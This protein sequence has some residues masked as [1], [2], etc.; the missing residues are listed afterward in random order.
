VRI[1]SDGNVLI[2][3]RDPDTGTGVATSLPRIIADEL[4][5]DWKSVSVVPL[6]LGVTNN[7]GEPSWTYGRQIGGTG[8][9]IP[10]AW[11]D[12]RQ[13]GRV[14]RW[15]LLQAA[16]RRFGVPAD[17]L[18]CE[19]GTVIAPDGRRLSYGSLPATPARSPCPT[20]HRHR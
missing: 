8:G 16:A 13:A 1:D 15:L 17:R 11:N 10:A 9:S 19:K 7:N 12:L 4:D 18:R 2:G 6:G 14:A 3:A 5:A 20:I